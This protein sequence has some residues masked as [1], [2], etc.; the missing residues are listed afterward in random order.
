M[1]GNLRLRSVLYL[2]GAN[3]RALDKARGLSADA[4]VLDLEDAV[5]PSAKPAVRER[6]RD[7]V[8]AGAY[9][10][11][12]V[13]VRVNAIDTEWHADDLAAVAA[14]APDA[15]LI[16]KLDSATDVITVQ[17]A[18]EA[19]GAPERT[20]IW[21]MLETPSAVLRAHE[22]ASA[23]PRLTA[24]V[25]G[26]NDLQAELHAEPVSGRVPLLASLSLCILAARSAGKAILDGVYNDIHDLEGLEAECLQGRSLGFDGKTLIHPAQIEVCNRVFSPSPEAVQHARRVIDAF[27]RAAG[28]GVGVATLDGQMIEQLHV[29]S[30]RRL[31]AQAGL[32]A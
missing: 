12:V 24:L 29:D 32:G 19:A 30:A 22:I 18:L 4:L 8:I 1:S 9:A 14:A 3:E 11:R 25:V 16:P 28:T 7:L 6:V 27:Q 13:A 10:G 17:G 20:E 23:S 15:V 5:A 31:L 2:P 26:T 21:A